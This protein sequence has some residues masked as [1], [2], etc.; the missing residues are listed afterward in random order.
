MWFSTVLFFSFNSEKMPNWLLLEANWPYWRMCD[1]VYGT[2]SLVDLYLLP[3][4]P[5]SLMVLFSNH[6]VALHTSYTIKGHLFP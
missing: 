4:E 2:L 3:V 6:G 5:N 1:G